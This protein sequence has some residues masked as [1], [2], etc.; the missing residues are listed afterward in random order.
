MDRGTIKVAFRIGPGLSRDALPLLVGVG[1]SLLLV[2]IFPRRAS[3]CLAW[4]LVLVAGVANEWADYLHETWPGRWQESLKDMLTTMSIPTRLLIVGRF[5]PHL[6]V[7][8][9][10]PDD[11]VEAGTGQEPA[12]D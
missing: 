7:R 11:M 4:L 10:A 3:L 5:A 12:G 9:A 2:A 1:L 6:L 8:P